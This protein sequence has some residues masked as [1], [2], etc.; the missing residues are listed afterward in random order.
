MSE[1]VCTNGFCRSGIKKLKVCGSCKSV[2]YCS[3]ACQTIH[4]KQHRSLCKIL[5]SDIREVQKRALAD[6]TM[7]I[8]YLNPKKGQTLELNAADTLPAIRVNKHVIKM[9]ELMNLNPK[10]AKPMLYDPTFKGTYARCFRNV[11]MVQKHR[12]GTTACGWSLFEGKLC[13]EAE[14]HAVW[15]PPDSTQYVNTTL[16]SYGKQYNGIFIKDKYLVENNRSPPNKLYWK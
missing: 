11:I 7:K 1:W 14:Y 5:T 6:G 9:L 13:V 10:D 15:V 16:N 3:I 2:K 12:G 4:W 8:D